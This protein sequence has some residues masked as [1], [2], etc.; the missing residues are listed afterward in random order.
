MVRTRRTIYAVVAEGKLKKALR[1]AYKYAN[2]LG[3]YKIVLVHPNMEVRVWSDTDSWVD[4]I[5]VT[6]TIMIEL[7][8]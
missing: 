2:P 1:L 7:G 5:A 8:D 3:R 4:E 6:S